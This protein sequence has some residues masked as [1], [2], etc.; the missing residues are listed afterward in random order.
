MKKTRLIG[1]AA[2]VITILLASTARAQ[3]GAFVSFKGI[4]ISSGHSETDEVYGWMCYARTTGALPGNLTLTMDYAGGKEPG[5]S[6]SVTDGAWTL[7]VY[8]STI[9]GSSYMG[10]LYGSVAT[11]RVTWDKS[12]TANIELKLTISGG[13][14]S[15]SDIRGMA[16]LSATVSY[17]EKGVGTFH[18]TMYFEFQRQSTLRK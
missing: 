7:P 8:G 14:Q 10:V 18:G 17:D 9:K 13:T 3:E 1:F 6:S 16:A 11:G 5:L 2:A 4:E 12:G 15:M